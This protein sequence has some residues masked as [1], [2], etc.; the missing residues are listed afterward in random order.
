MKDVPKD[1]SIYYIHIKSI[2]KA[3]NVSEIV[4][5]K[6]EL[7]ETTTSVPK[8]ADNTIRVDWNF[9]DTDLSKYYFQKL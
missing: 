2:D 5:K 4:H 9:S 8:E 3:G 1:D 7:H 6:I